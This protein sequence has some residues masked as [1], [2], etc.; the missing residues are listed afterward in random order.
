MTKEKQSF[1]VSVDAIDPDEGMEIDERRPFDFFFSEEDGVNA[2][3][4][5]E[6]RLSLTKSG[7]EIFAG[8]LLSGTIRLQCS[9]CLENFD[10]LVEAPVEAPFFPADIPGARTA[11]AGHA[12]KAA[13][14]DEDEIPADEGDV[15][16]YS[17]DALN[18]YNVMRDQVFLALPLKP[19]CK[20]DCKGLCPKCGKDLNE[21]P[22]GC[23]EQKPDPRLAVLKKLKDKL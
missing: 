12:K 16:Y 20:E 2:V 1:P 19:L 4:E 9:R 15:N 14:Q 22:C 17:G 8:G 3:S 23:K 6:I 13:D 10:F 21:G 18:L 11:A 7:D 5:V